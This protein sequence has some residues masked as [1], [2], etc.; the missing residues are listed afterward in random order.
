MQRL[1]EINFNG[2]E[3]CQF[4]DSPVGRE[5]FLA[6]LKKQ[7]VVRKNEIFAESIGEQIFDGIDNDGSFYKRNFDVLV[8]KKK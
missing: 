7:G 8:K 3:I 5:A 4:F 2:D 1:I 6:F